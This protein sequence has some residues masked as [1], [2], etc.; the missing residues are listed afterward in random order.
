MNRKMHSTLVDIQITK[1]LPDNLEKFLEKGTSC[2]ALID[3][4]DA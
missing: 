1:D 2:C 3:F 4:A